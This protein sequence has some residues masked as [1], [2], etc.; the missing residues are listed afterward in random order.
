MVAG[1]GDEWIVATSQ[2]KEH[3]G[4]RKTSVV[5]GKEA[6]KIWHGSDW[7]GN[8]FF[9]GR[10]PPRTINEKKEEYDAERNSTWVIRLR[11]P[12]RRRSVT[13]SCEFWSCNFETEM[14]HF[15]GSLHRFLNNKAES[16]E[17]D[18]NKIA[19]N[20]FWAYQHR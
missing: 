3:T 6:D 10:H 14:G 13:S 20:L 11:P 2:R 16:N 19:G 7:P 15:F 17:I 18:W 1:E 5:N 4:G 12:R 8:R 9:G